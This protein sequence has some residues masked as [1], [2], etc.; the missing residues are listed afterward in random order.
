MM[1]ASL[2]MKCDRHIFLSFW[3]IFGPFTPLLTQKLKFEKNVQKTWR[4][5]PF[6]HV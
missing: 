3:A 4:Y 5:Y 2:G 6:T 1:H